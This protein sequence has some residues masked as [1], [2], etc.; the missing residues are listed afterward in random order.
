MTKII[1]M[2]DLLEDAKVKY[3]EKFGGKTTLPKPKAE[4][5]NADYHQTEPVQFKKPAEP[6]LD[7]DGMP[8]PDADQKEVLDRNEETAEVSV[9]SCGDLT[10]AQKIRQMQA[11][12]VAGLNE[13]KKKDEKKKVSKKKKDEKKSKKSK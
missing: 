4:K 1:K 5:H 6:K 11:R 12:L 2:A 13:A 7:K 10:E 9:E 8:T 3:V